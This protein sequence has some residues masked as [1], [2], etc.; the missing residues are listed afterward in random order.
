MDKIRKGIDSVKKYIQN[1]RM[2]LKRVTWPSK[3]ELRASTIVV[4]LTLF[5]VTA[6]LWVWDSIFLKI[7][8]KLKGY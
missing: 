2:E 4:L 8:T 6:Y 1:V 7:F 5:A 3:Q